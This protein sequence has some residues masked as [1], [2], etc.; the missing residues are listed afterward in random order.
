[1]SDVGKKKDKGS[2]PDFLN[3]KNVLFL[4]VV[5]ACI[6]LAL[7]INLHVKINELNIQFEKKYEN[8]LKNNEHILAKVED[9]YKMI[10]QYNNIKIR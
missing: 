8:I 2:K 9:L 7:F 6:F 3:R 5:V 10:E 4:S 1:M